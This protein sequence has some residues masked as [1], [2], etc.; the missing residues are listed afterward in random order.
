MDR[1]EDSRKHPLENWGYCAMWASQ[2]VASISLAYWQRN[3]QVRRRD[4]RARGIRPDVTLLEEKTLLST[5]NLTV[6]T[7]ADDPSGSILG[8]TT[9]RDAITQ[10]DASTNGQEVINFAVTG[11]INLKNSL[12]DL[13]HNLAL[14]GPGVSELT[15]QRDP[16]SAD[17]SVFTVHSGATVTIS[18]ITVSGGDSGFGSSVG[19]GGGLDNFGTATVSNSVFSG[20]S[21]VLGGAIDNEPGGSLTVTGTSFTNNSVNGSGGGI[22]NQG[23][24]VVTNS[25]FTGNSGECGGAIYSLS[26]LTVIS[27]SLTDNL[28]TDGGAIA[29]GKSTASV[30]NS[31]F[32]GNSAD[33][34]SGIYN[35]GTTAVND[36]NFSNNSSSAPTNNP[37]YFGG[38]GVF[39]YGT[40]TVSDS[41]FTGNSATY[42]GGGLVNASGTVTVTG[43]T[44]TGNTA[45][46]GSGAAFYNG[47]GLSDGAGSATVTAS[48]FTGNSA[49]DGSGLDNHNNGTLTITNCTISGNASQYGGVSN[50]GVGNL[51]L[52]NTIVAG[53]TS[54]SSSG[55]DINGQVNPVSAFNLIGDGAGISDLTNLEKPALSNLIGTA[56]DPLNPMLGPLATNG[57]PTETMALLPGSP[58]IQAGS[59]ALA[60]DASGKPLT[61][62]Q[63]DAGYP[64]VVNGN[65]DIGAYEFTQLTQTVSFG[66]LADQIYG[67]TP[68]TLQAQASS[69]LPVD[70]AVV[71]GPAKLSG[72]VLT[73][74]GAGNLVIGAS[75]PGNVYYSPATTC[76]RVIHSR[77]RSPG[78]HANKGQVDDVRRHRAATDLYLHWPR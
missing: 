49:T 73:V 5:L 35:A 57:G 66:P 69:A 38:G 21:A 20:N 3:D 48:T 22:E 56:A 74:T 50:E 59:V 23:T 51:T 15:V 30:S 2:L 63:R 42:D 41:S 16:N 27:S 52:N 77:P 8:Y 31:T 70:F 62:D 53:N 11:T 43:S 6:N 47:V 40:L 64:R 32:T 54:S 1:A 29:I 12:P 19:D 14:N 58:A 55:N 44:F 13:S 9:L 68:I 76:K 71:S 33:A 61:T 60:V 10:A 45:T 65:V 46:S 37:A 67:V 4:R 26:V 72:S 17:F 39:N 24:T 18:G 25:I 78:H 7:L 28:G 34:G 36:S 75:Q